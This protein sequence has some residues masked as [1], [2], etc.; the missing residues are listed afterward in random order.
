MISGIMS[1]TLLRPRSL[2][3]GWS[4]DFKNLILKKLSKSIRLLSKWFKRLLVLKNKNNTKIIRKNLMRQMK[5]CKIETKISLKPNSHR[6]NPTKLH[7]V[8]N[9]HQNNTWNT[10]KYN[11][12]PSLTTKTKKAWTTFKTWEKNNKKRKSNSKIIIKQQTINHKIKR[13]NSPNKTQP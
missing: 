9:L 6:M 2:M 13:K 7:Q 4:L 3:K 12:N 10:S 11:R 1:L 8:K 5:I